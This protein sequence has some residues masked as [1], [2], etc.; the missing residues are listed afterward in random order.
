M[1]ALLTQRRALSFSTAS[2]TLPAV[3][4]FW[5]EQS[6]EFFDDNIGHIKSSH[7]DLVP[8]HAVL[9]FAAHPVEAVDYPKHISRQSSSGG[10]CD[11]TP[12]LSVRELTPNIQRMEL[13]GAQ[14]SVNSIRC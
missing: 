12:L 5:L 10:F 11:G 13:T 2:G 9:E 1:V 14:R 3:G 6:V 4:A 8:L 7:A